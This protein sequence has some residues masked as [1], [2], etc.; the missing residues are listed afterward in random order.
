M[1]L[2]VNQLAAPCYGGNGAL[3]I[4][5]GNVTFHRCIYSLEALGGHPDFFGAARP[6]DVLSVR[7]LVAETQY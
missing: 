1:G 2:Q 6:R 7:W 5:G 4:T 3:N